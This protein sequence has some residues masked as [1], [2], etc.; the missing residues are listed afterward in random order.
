MYCPTCG[1]NLT[2]S[3]NCLINGMCLDCWN[4]QKYYTTQSDY[5]YKCPDCN[6]EFNQPAM[7]SISSTWTTYKC[8]FCGR[9][10]KGL[11]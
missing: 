2:D 8:P 1:K 3:T 6:G 10:M 5:N 9:T 4:Q 11:K 7:Q